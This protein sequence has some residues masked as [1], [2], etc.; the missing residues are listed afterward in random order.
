M[1]KMKITKT[2]YMRFGAILKLKTGNKVY[3]NTGNYV[4]YTV[5]V[6]NAGNVA[7]RR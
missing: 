5:I 2:T 3:D 6:T 1:P 4:D 7:I